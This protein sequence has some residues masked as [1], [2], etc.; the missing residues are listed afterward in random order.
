MA[1][2]A[3]RLL[4]QIMSMTTSNLSRFHFAL[5][6]FKFVSIALDGFDSIRQAILTLYRD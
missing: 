1:L 3:W 4:K 6:G 2:S 5:E